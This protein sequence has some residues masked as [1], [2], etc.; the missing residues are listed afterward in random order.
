MCKQR[1]TR[2]TSLFPPYA[3]PLPSFGPSFATLTLLSQKRAQGESDAPF[4]A[5][6]E[7][8]APL[9]PL[10]PPPPICAPALRPVHARTGLANA[11]PHGTRHT[12]PLPPCPRLCANGEPHRKGARPPLS[13]PAPVCAQ[14]G[15]GKGT[16]S[17]LAPFRPRSRANRTQETRDKPPPFAPPPSASFTREQG[18]RTRDRTGQGTPLCTHAT[19]YARKGGGRT[20]RHPLHFRPAAPF[21]HEGGAGKVRPLFWPASAP[22][23]T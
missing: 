20:A 10:L 9:P 6:R 18:T 17:P 13:L 19:V 8:Y 21:K 1:V 2:A 16:P 11:G 14:R 15:R 22:I 3:R 4:C 12:P 7:R 5:P 23:H